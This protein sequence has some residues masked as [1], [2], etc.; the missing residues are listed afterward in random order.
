MSVQTIIFNRILDSQ[1]FSLWDGVKL[2]TNN[3]IIKFTET[4]EIDVG[5]KHFNRIPENINTLT[6]VGD[7][8]VVKINSF[9]ISELQQI[10]IVGNNVKIEKEAFFNINCECINIIGNFVEIDDGHFLTQI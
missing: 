5:V 1:Y 4:Y 2:E 9:K 8:I 10:N 3:L 6:I 7:N